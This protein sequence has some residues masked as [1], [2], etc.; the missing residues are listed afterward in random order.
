KQAYRE[1]R[2][3]QEV[4]AQETDLSVEELKALLDPMELTRGG[5]KG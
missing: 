2:P 5:I 1:G 3:I 4:A